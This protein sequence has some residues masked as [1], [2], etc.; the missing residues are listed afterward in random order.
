MPFNGEAFKTYSIYIVDF[1]RRH[2]LQALKFRAMSG[3]N[4]DRNQNAQ[5]LLFRRAG[6]SFLI[7][8]TR[9]L[10]KFSKKRC[11]T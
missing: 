1:N 10:F 9:S 5:S 4:S 8:C 3:M 11:S 6:S 7:K 2:C